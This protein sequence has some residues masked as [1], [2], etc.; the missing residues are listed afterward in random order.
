MPRKRDLRKEAEQA[1]ELLRARSTPKDL[2]NLT[3]FG[4]DAKKPLGVSMANIQQVGKQIGRDHE[5]ALALWETGWYEARMLTAFVDEPDKV[6]V[7]QMD[8]WC[9]DFDNWGIVDTMCFCLFD[10]SPHAWSRIEPWSKKTDEQGKRAAFALLASL[11]GHDQKSG[12]EPF[13]ATLPL[14]EKAASDDRNFVKKGVSW[15]LRRMALRSPKLR[16]AC[17]E[18]A[19]R[20]AASKEP[21]ARWLGKET[22]REIERAKAR[23]KVKAKAKKAT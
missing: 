16:K 14:I 13:L 8:R 1:V 6:T 12:D 18:L 5:L 10:R 20:L 19:V 15:A 17:G 23:K 22:L 3:R 4:I 21:S 11:A 9:R 2:A 7:A